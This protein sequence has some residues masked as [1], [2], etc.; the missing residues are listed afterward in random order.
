MPEFRSIRAR[1]SVSRI[2][3]WAAV[4]GFFAVEILCGAIQFP[5]SGPGDTP[6]A[7]EG[8][9]AI[10]SAAYAGKRGGGGGDFG[11]GNFRGGDFD[12]GRDRDGGSSRGIDRGGDRDRSAPSR[13]S[14]GAP[15]DSGQAIRP[16]P[17]SQAPAAASPQID[18]SGRNSVSGRDVSSVN[19]DAQERGGQ[20]RNSDKD[21]KSGKSRSSVRSQSERSGE[22]ARPPP[23]TV[24][25]VFERLFK[26]AETTEK[27]AQSNASGANPTTKS[28]NTTA[29]AAKT[30]ATA[31]PVTSTSAA[32]SAASSAASN[33]PA[34][35]KAAPVIGTNGSAGLDPFPKR[36]FTANEILAE[37]LKPSTIERALQRG[38]AI[39]TTSR[40]SHLRSSVTRIVIPPDMDALQ[41]LTWLQ[42]ELPSEK[43]AL[44]RI[45]GLYRAANQG[46]KR[47]A[48]RSTSARQGV[49]EVCEGDRCA[50]RDVIQWKS[51]LQRCSKG[52][53]V[54]V[55]DTGIDDQH[56]AFPAGKLN[57]GTFIPDGQTPAP[58]WH[59]TG[60][61]S[62]LAGRSDSGTP[63]LIPDG[64]FYAAG[65]FFTDPSGE[66]ATD[67]VSIL[68]ALDW[69][70]AYDVKLINM[71]F[72]GPRDELVQKAIA[73]LSA[74]GMVF[75]AAAGNEG[76]SAPPSYPA[77]YKQVMAVTAVNKDLRNYAY[78]NRGGHID[79]AAPGVQIW[80][81]APD[82]KE[83]YRSGTSFAAPHVTAIVATVLFGSPRRQKD[84]LLKALKIVDLGPPGRDPI[85]GHGLLMAPTGCQPGFSIETAIATPGVTPTSAAPSQTSPATPA[86]WSTDV[87][88]GAASGGLSLTGGAG[89]R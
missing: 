22:T 42:G 71:S 21:D 74:K 52:L 27:S 60:V 64:E 4:F 50:G 79:V 87:T 82:A 59:G 75:V 53:R 62:L 56:P 51:E 17:S 32:G 8:G 80:T 14:S 37:N 26:A 58:T 57:L 24:V 9:F 3:S 5:N 65:V 38:F 49:T 6:L 88:M 47:E 15:R 28:I 10:V 68:K 63:G 20:E 29:P 48:G 78:A 54:G 67:T 69:M 7:G 41:A 33:K 45:Y 39:G 66:F 16:T 23:A 11:R 86:S 72:A 35:A 31:K 36:S 55:I 19:R 25:E 84:D 46:A 12:R 73:R 1:A 2:R 83:G 44:N 13:E 70:S 61:L 30:P 77:G 81:A 40:L 89:V 43:F 85:Y 76:P 18:P 34:T